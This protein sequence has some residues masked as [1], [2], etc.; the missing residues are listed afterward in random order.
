M[1][2][3]TKTYTIESVKCSKC[4]KS[5]KPKDLVMYYDSVTKTKSCYHYKCY[6]KEDL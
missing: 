3:R 4:G 1:A 6:L 2:D 5:I